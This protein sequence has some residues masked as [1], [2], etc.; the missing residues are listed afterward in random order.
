MKE[1][2]KS[3]AQPQLETFGSV[4]EMTAAT[5]SGTVYKASYGN[6]SQDNGQIWSC[7]A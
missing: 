4:E 6:D 2:K 5:C 1:N 3:W 7:L